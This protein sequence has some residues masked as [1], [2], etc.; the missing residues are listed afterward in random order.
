MQLQ[1]L[2]FGSFKLKAP[3]DWYIVKQQ[4]TDSHAGGLTNGK[5]SLWFDYGWYDVTI[6]QDL[7]K[8]QLYARDTVNGLAADI[9][10]PSNDSEGYISM[11]LNIG[12]KTKFTIWKFT[13]NT[14]DFFFTC[15]LKKKK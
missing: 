2:D 6:E 4:G 8:H 7:G 11:H 15:C 14:S 13:A 12:E 1:Q 5:D 9:L 3:K 10:I